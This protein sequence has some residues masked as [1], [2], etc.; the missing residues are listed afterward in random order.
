MI[1]HHF[2]V[3]FTRREIRYIGVN[4]YLNLSKLLVETVDRTDWCLEDT[5]AMMTSVQHGTDLCSLVVDKKFT[6]DSPNEWFQ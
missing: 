3:N 2:F 4:A 6:T 5:I 1:E